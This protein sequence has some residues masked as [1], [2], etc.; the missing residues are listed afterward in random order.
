MP[1][2]RALPRPALF[3]AFA[4]AALLER[5]LHADQTVKVTVSAGQHDRSCTPI[6]VEFA[7]DSTLKDSGASLEDESGKWYINQLTSPSLLAS[8]APANE[9]QVAR[10]L[11]FI[12]PELKAG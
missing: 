12:L 7:V 11:N 5:P 10:E 6:C 4:L 8:L 2:I 9:N 3:L 1:A